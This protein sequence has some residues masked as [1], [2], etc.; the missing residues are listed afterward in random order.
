MVIP[1]TGL[2]TAASSVNFAWAQFALENT[3]AEDL[4]AAMAAVARLLK[5]EGELGLAESF[6]MWIE[7]VLEPMLGVQ[8][9]SLMNMMEEPPMLAETLDEWAEEKFRLGQVA[10]MEQGM[11]RG[12]EQGRFR[13][14]VEGERACSSARRGGG[15]ASRCL[16]HCQSWL[17]VLTTRTASPRWGTLVVHCATGRELLDRVLL[18]FR[19]NPT[20]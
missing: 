13:G 8:L 1:Y 5:A 7:G 9:P 4:A 12:M 19:A 17:R 15:L 14:R 10:G 6:G 3:S 18:G 2:R 16:R 20:V 11:E